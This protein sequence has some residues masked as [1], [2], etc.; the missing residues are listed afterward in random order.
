[1]VLGACKGKRSTAE[2]DN[3][4]LQS[5]SIK[6]YTD[7]IARDTANAGLYYQRGRALRAIEEDSMAINDFKRA[8]WLDSTRAEYYSA[9]GNILFEHKDIAGSVQ[10]LQQAIKR[11]PTDP[12]AHLK[13]AKLFLYTQDYPK[14]FSELNIVLRQDVYNPEP[15]FLK[16]MIYLD[17]KDTAK[18]ISNLQ[19]A[20]QVMPTYRDAV[21]QLGQVYSAQG[22]PVALKYYDNAFRIDTLD[23]FPLFAKGV[24]YQNMGDYNSAK[25]QYRR[26]I[27]YD[28]Q[29]ADAYFNMGWV[30]LQQ[31]SIDKALRQYD[32][33]TRIEPNNADAYYNRGLCHEML[34]KKQEAIND[35]K[36]ALQFDKDYKDAQNALR[37]L[38]VQ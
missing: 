10:W 2:D 14:A 9:I 18:G 32:L 6:G 19:T 3:P 29:Y 24:Y 27:W 8:I 38:G 12:A 21:I 36:L 34:N 25:E 5:A 37:K 11:N 33:V 4:V 7:Q 35:Y 28:Q 31:D 26:C 1:M 16:G 17:M 13:I 20:V 22:N 23:V 15:Y 30:L